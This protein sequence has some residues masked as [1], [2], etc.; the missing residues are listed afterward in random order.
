M[1]GVSRGWHHSFIHDGR[2]DRNDGWTLVRKLSLDP[3]QEIGGGGDS[4]RDSRGK[5]NRRE[6]I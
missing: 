5:E 6:R 4:G 2:G 1:E 3:R